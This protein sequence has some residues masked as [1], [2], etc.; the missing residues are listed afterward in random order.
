MKRNFLSSFLGRLGDLGGSSLAS[1]TILYLIWEES[2]MADGGRERER[3]ERLRKIMRMEK[4]E[5][6]LSKKFPLRPL[7]IFLTHILKGG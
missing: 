4:K 2:A 5:N 1:K 7:V 3:L 6:N